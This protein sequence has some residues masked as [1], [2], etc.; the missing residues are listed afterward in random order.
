MVLVL[1]LW[2]SESRFLDRAHDQSQKLLASLDNAAMRFAMP[3]KWLHERSGLLSL[4]QLWCDR[5][6]LRGTA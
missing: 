4:K 1:W 6:P 5:A 2:G 3:N